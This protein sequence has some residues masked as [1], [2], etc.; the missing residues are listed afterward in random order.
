MNDKALEL[1]MQ[2]TH[3]ANPAGLDDSENYSTVEDLEKLIHYTYEKRNDLW[4]I[5]RTAAGE[6]IGVS[7]KQY[8]FSTTN[9]LL[10]E[11]PNTIYGGKTGFT[12]EAQGALILLYQ[13]VPQETVSIVILGSQDRFQ[14]GRNIIQWLNTAFIWPK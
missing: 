9:E 4:G 5:S 13:P 14:D 3:F 12:D 6:I 11:M 1:D 2:S 7:G 10:K 8:H